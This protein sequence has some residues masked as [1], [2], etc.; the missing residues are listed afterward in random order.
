M[1]TMRLVIA[2]CCHSPLPSH[3]LRLSASSPRGRCAGTLQLPLWP[4]VRALLPLLPFLPLSL[5]LLS[6]CAVLRDSGVYTQ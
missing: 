2:V 6:A 4:P 1:M 5:F 3:L